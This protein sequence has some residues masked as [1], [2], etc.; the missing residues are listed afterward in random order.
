MTRSPKMHL[1]S[2]A[3]AQPL[4][5]RRHSRRRRAR[6]T[7]RAR[8]RPRREVGADRVG[9]APLR[10]EAAALAALL[11]RRTPRRG[12]GSRGTTSCSADRGRR[13]P[14][15]GRDARRQRVELRA[16]QWTRARRSPSRRCRAQG[17]ERQAG[18]AGQKSPA[19]RSMS[20][21]ARRV[22]GSRSG[23]TVWS[24]DGIRVS[25]PRSPRRRP[26]SRRRCRG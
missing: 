24:V 5:E 13:E 15:R 16:G 21:A 1:P 7:V 22:R 8:T 11:L 10:R 20:C 2:V 18:K 17:D 25:A 19:R 4:G 6:R 23:P 14:G 26:P 12:R 3:P 9:Q